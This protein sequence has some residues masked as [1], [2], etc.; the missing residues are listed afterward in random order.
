MAGF[1]AAPAAVA[2]PFSALAIDIHPRSNTLVLAHGQDGELRLVDFAD[3]AKPAARALPPKATAA[4]FLPD[5]RLVVGGADGTV[6]LWSLETGAEA[7]AIRASSSPILSLAVSA[8]HIAGVDEKLTVRLWQQDGRGVGHAL[9]MRRQKSEAPCATSAVGL[10]PDESAVAAIACSGDVYVWTL[11]GQAVAVPRGR[12]EYEGCC[13]W[14]IGFTADGRHLIARRSFQPGYD[15]YVWTRRGGRLAGGRQFPGTEQLRQFAV[16]PNTPELLILDE[17][18]LRRLTP[19][20]AKGAAL[21]P[22]EKDAPA[23]M[24][25]FA[26]SSDGT[27]IAT[28]EGE[29]DVVYRAGDGKILGRLALR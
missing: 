27:R 14:Q 12:G 8:R 22:K 19:A 1:A 18:G 2:D 26:V 20:G 25:G 16:L 4:A 24:R 9:Q 21:L 17:L 10:A 7:A 3:P 6:R 15:A 23:T 13:G 29:D 5:G 28:I 11:A